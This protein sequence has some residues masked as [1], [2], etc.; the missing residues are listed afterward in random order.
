M[1]STSR[2][3]RPVAYTDYYA[4]A[5]GIDRVEGKNAWGLYKKTLLQFCNV[6]Q[7]DIQRVTAAFVALSPNSDYMGNLRSLRTC[8]DHVMH[9]RRDD[10]ACIVSTF[11]TCKHRALSY[12]RGEVDFLETVKGPKIRAF[13]HNILTP[14]DDRH[15]TIDGHMFCIWLGVNATMREVAL[16]RP[17]YKT[18]SRHLRIAAKRLDYS[19]CQLQA[20][21]WFARKRALHIKYNAQLD[22]F[23]EDGNAWRTF[24]PYKEI[25]PYFQ[26]R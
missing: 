18:A 23:Q 19:P 7:I 1:A 2:I 13:Y 17:D 22:L 11:N 4:L 25:I 15:V 9:S 16:M 8:V 10:N 20:V 24:V 14:E 21:L 6:S 3:K 26:Q 12:L 5:D